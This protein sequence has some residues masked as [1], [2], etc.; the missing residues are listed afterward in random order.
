MPVFV[1]KTTCLPSL[2]LRH[3]S[4]EVR[5]EIIPGVLETVLTRFWKSW[6]QCFFSDLCVYSHDTLQTSTSSSP[7]FDDWTAPPT[8]WD[9]N[10]SH[11]R[12]HSLK[13]PWLPCSAMPHFFH[14]FSLVTGEIS[15]LRR[16]S[17]TP[18]ETPSSE[19]RSAGT[20]CAAVTA[21]CLGSDAQPRGS[22]LF[23]T[24]GRE[25]GDS[26][27]SMRVWI[28]GVGRVHQ[29]CQHWPSSKTTAVSILVVTA[30]SRSFEVLTLRLWQWSVLRCV[31]SGWR[32]MEFSLIRRRVSLTRPCA[33]DGGTVDTRPV[34]LPGDCS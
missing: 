20:A 8:A 6:L 17:D 15:A 14:R 31:I 32:A 21:T 4:T 25:V 33:P 3:P 12:S 11:G 10:R 2:V 1:S 28:C 26:R 18:S 19:R 23:G 16:K 24:S 27:L 13:G 29:L 9:E 7:L 5:S 22:L 34:D 30:T